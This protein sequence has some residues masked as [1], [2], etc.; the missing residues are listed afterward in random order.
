MTLINQRPPFNVFHPRVFSAKRLPSA[1]YM[2]HF[3]RYLIALI[4]SI[5]GMIIAVVLW[6]ADRSEHEN[7]L[8]LYG[9]DPLWSKMSSHDILWIIFTAVLALTTLALLLSAVRRQSNKRS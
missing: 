5:V 2:K 9:S 3:R 7:C 8:R 6:M 4:L 1:N